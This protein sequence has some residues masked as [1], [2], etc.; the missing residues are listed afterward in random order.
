[1]ISLDGLGRELHR[2]EGEEPLVSATTSAELGR[3]GLGE[4][5]VQ[6]AVSLDT[7]AFA[8]GQEVNRRPPLSHQDALDEPAGMDLA[9]H[10]G[11]IRP[12][13]N[14]WGRLGER[15]ESL[16]GIL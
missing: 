12:G 5:K 1:M 9:I 2:P 16:E 8:V 6:T 15:A 4:L 13:I 7:W 11:T 14:P 3:L 10:S